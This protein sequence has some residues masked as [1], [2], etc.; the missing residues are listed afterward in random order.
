MGAV[1]LTAGIILTAC[2]PTA[3]D[4]AQPSRSRL[5][6]ELQRAVTIMN[7]PD[8]LINPI[9]MQESKISVGSSSSASAGAQSASSEY[10]HLYQQVLSL[11]QMTPAQAQTLVA[12]DLTL[13]E[14][15]VQAVNSQGFIEAAQY[16]TTAQQAQQQF[17]SAST[18]HDLFTY[19]RILEAQ[20]VA[21]NDLM[22]VYQQLQALDALVKSQNEALG[23]QANAGPQPLQCAIGD[24]GAFF[25]PDPIVTVTLSYGGPAQSYEFDQWPQHDLE[26][27]RAA[28]GD[29]QYQALA[30]LIR[31]Q[32]SQMQA[33][34]AGVLPQ[35][36]SHLVT[37]FEQDVTEYQQDGGTDARYSQQAA[38]DIQTLASA[39][40]LNQLSALAATIQTQRQAIAFPLTRARAQHDLQ[41]LQGLV[42][43]ANAIQVTDPANG[44][45]YPLAYEYSND[46]VGIGD[47]YAR[48]NQASSLADYQVVDQEIQMFITNIQA[49]LQ[50]LNDNTPSNQIHATDVSLM[51]HY[52]VYGEKVVVVS[53]SEQQMRIYDN[54]KL[55]HTNLVTTG[56]PDLPTPA[57]IHC[58]QN[59]LYHTEFVSPY[60]KGSP[61]YYYP[62]PINYAMLVSDYGFYMHDAWWRAWFGKYSNLPHY[63]PISFNN[64]SHGCI[65]MPLSDAAWVF[66]WVTIGTPVIVY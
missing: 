8:S 31:A 6:A 17:A 47:A 13:Y 30:S 52:G 46:G 39:K 24:N 48:L 50:N 34:V 29:A 27:F 35:E 18:T 59:K 23:I 33:D 63:D 36:A 9:K 21:L 41:T 57:G 26:L 15:A 66:N 7:M 14:T 22:P 20:T 28:T 43:K 58:V 12:K 49:M 4:N 1:A 32:T 56:A 40:N 3:Q 37:L 42:N 11:E 38:Q 16:E 45:N 44:L 53:L 25:T 64:G 19:A 61:D 62:T 2:A 5:D 10:D 51:Q 65:N 60:P 54:G 55:V